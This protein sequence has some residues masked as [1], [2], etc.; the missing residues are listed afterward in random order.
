MTA[1]TQA[2]RARSERQDLWFFIVV[3]AIAAIASIGAAVRRLL[4]LFSP[5]GIAISVPLEQMPAE[6]ALGVQGAAVSVHV[7]Q[8]TVLVPDL[9][10]LSLIMLVATI[11]AQAL[12]VLV[13]A[14]CALLLCR[15]LMRG[16]AFGRA[17]TKLIFTSFYVVLAGAVLSQ[18]GT[19]LGL[20]GVF[21]ALAG[22]P[23]YGT[24]YTSNVNILASFWPSYLAAIALGAIAIA[25]R[26]GEALQRDAEGLV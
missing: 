21:A 20:N 26:R 1:A 25:F 7:T 14:V 15:N 12:T 2:K 24:E 4:E 6:L 17:N 13:V 8:A 16:A 18:A 9:N 11:I 22:T 10:T 23:T 3:G 19:T 5:D